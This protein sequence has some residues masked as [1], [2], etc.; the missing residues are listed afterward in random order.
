MFTKEL[1]LVCEPVESIRRLRERFANL[2]IEYCILKEIL[3]E[4]KNSDELT[5][6]NDRPKFSRFAKK[7]VLELPA[8]IRQK[9][10][11]STTDRD[12]LY[13]S[14][15]VENVEGFSKFRH[16]SFCHTKAHSLVH[17][18]NIFLCKAFFFIKA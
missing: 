10:K 4:S 11:E 18:F 5:N 2:Q 15:G 8:T 1:F 7:K 14:C 9:S 3:Q 6:H 13:Y 12:F 17:F 16:E